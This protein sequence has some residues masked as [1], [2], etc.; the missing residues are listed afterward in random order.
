MHCKNSRSAGNGVFQLNG[1][2]SRVMVAS[3]A[4]VVFDQMA[5]PVPEIMVDYFWVSNEI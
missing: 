1:T 4:K 2:T 5:E 3:R